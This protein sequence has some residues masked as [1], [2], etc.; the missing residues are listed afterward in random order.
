M[1]VTT[2]IGQRDVCL[3][4]EGQEEIQPSRRRRCLGEGRKRK[5]LK[6]VTSINT[7]DSEPEATELTRKAGE[8]RREAE[9]RK[10]IASTTVTSLLL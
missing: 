3:G 2:N 6:L 4:E 10:V 7:Q 1:S 5:N 9:D 8:R